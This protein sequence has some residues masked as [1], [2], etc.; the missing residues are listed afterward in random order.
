MAI[1][2]EDAVID[3]GTG[4]AGGYSSTEAATAEYINENDVPFPYFWEPISTGCSQIFTKNTYTNYK[5][6]AGDPIMGY[7]VPSAG[8]YMSDP[9]YSRAEMYDGTS[10]LHCILRGHVPL[11]KSVNYQ[12]YA[13]E[14]SDKLGAELVTSLKNYTSANYQYVPFWS[15]TTATSG[16]TL[17]RTDT[18]LK[19]GSTTFSQ[20]DFRGGVI[21]RY[22]Y[23]ICIGA[24]GGGGGIYNN[25]SAGGGGGGGVA[26]AVIDLVTATEW[27]ATITLKTGTGGTAGGTGTTLASSK[28]GNGGDTYIEF[29]AGYSAAGLLRGGGGTGGG[30]NHTAGSGGTNVICPIEL[31]NLDTV[32]LFLVETSIAGGAGSAGTY[33]NG[34]GGTGGNA[35]GTF[36]VLTV[37][38]VGSIST[39]TYFHHSIMP[40][41]HFGGTDCITNTSSVSGGGGASFLAEGGDGGL[42]DGTNYNGY[43][44]GGAGA[45]G[46]GGHYYLF[47]KAKGGAGGAGA[48][49]LYY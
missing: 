4:T 40:M 34:V 38:N 2:V 11:F 28:G 32:E 18:Q 17:T 3:K 49:L 8:T 27:D 5:D 26:A 15:T 36:S 29:D 24:G 41:T 10:Q 1:I 9:Y 16:V 21:P 43:A 42:D 12:G 20:N 47:T 7:A 46:G 37:A 45:G 35:A 39:K 31:D 23:A 48:I 44:A 22:I 25:G 13:A 14:V 6:S 19:I 33:T 30:G